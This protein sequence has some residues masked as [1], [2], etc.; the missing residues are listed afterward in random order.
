MRPE[1]IQGAT[2]KT[3]R[4][5]RGFTSLCLLAALLASL[6]AL[7]AA[8]QSIATTGNDPVAKGREDLRAAEAAHPGNT[9]EV[10]DAISDLIILLSENEQVDASAVPLAERGLA[11]ARAI[12]PRSRQMVNAL[13]AAA[14]VQTMLNHS[15]QARPLAEQAY[16]IAAKDYPNSEELISA[17]D[18]LSDAC[19]V[20]GDFDCALQA[21]RVTLQA[22]RSIGAKMDW[23]AVGTMSGIANILEQLNKPDE[24]ETTILEALASAIR[25]RP[26]A[27]EI[28]VLE[29]NA[30]QSLVRHKKFE[31]ATPHVERA[32]ELAEK[33]TGPDSW[34]TLDTIGF[35]ADLY[36]RTGRYAQAW[37]DYDRA[38]HNPSERMLFVARMRFNFSRSLAAGGDPVRAA[39]QAL[40]SARMTRETFVL[41][42]RTLPERQALAFEKDQPYGLSCALSVLL[43]HNQV[44]PVPVFEELMRSRALVADEMARRQRNLNQANDPDVARLIAELNQARAAAIDAQNSANAT[45]QGREAIRLATEKMEKVERALAEHSAQVRDDRRQNSATLTDLQASLPPRSALISYAY[46]WRVPVDK[47]DPGYGADASYMAFVLRPGD[48]TPAAFDLGDAKSIDDLVKRTREAADRQARSGGLG[49]LRNERLYRDAAG[50]LRK[51]IWDPLLPLVK[52]AGLA[53]VVPDGELNLIPF[54]SLPLGNGYMVE[55]K[56]VIHILTSERDLIPAHSVPKKAGILAIGNP[57]FGLSHPAPQ[58]SA[59]S[60]GSQPCTPIDQLQFEPLPGTAEETS[61]I[62]RSWQNWRAGGQAQLLSGKQATRERFLAEAG[63]YRFLHIATHAFLLDHRCGSSNPL[64]NSGLVFAGVNPKHEAAIVTAEQIASLDLSGVEWAVLSAC[65]TGN[66]EFHDGEGVLGLER[67]FRVAGAQSVVMTLWPVN[68][69]LTRNYMANLYAERIQRHA[70]TATATWNSSRQLLLARRAAGQSTH[71]WYWAGF[72]GAGALQ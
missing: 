40:E 25:Q 18:A 37:K 17:S 1:L 28:A 70:A 20:L 47:L 55:G 69:T 30:G 24:A 46:F 22:E 43:R 12:G 63:N 44:A 21:S 48:K 27:P 19:E 62:L 41:E 35:R 2:N 54:A 14:R 10:A 26:D 23:L 15:A 34:L 32:V 39:E 38:I 29:G 6:P 16:D 9:P 33:L 42:A 49:A 11:I 3:M 60:R 61:G 71:P 31:L 68:D 51:R 8:A 58:A 5:C 59:Q 53:L 50:A 65:N 45:D 56:T 36:T 7:R 57:D 4:S 66:G 67:A 64:L 13:A 72:V 52:D